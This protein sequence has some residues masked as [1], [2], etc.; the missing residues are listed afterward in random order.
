[1]PS[2]SIFVS[3]ATAD[4][5]LAD[6]LVVLIETGIG[7]PDSDVFC[8]SLEGL[9]IPSGANFVDFIKS[10]IQ[11]PRGVLLLLTPHYY[12]SEFCLCELGAS[13]SMAHRAFPLLLPPLTYDD[14]NGVLLGTQVLRLNSK[15]KLNQFQGEMVELFKIKGKAFAIWE[16]RRD[17]F[18]EWIDGYIKAYTPPKKVDPD[19]HRE[20]EKNYNEAKEALSDAED[21]ISTLEGQIEKLKQLKD[22]AAADAVLEADIEDV[23]KFETLVDEAV[24]AMSGFPREVDNALFLHFRGEELEWP[25]FGYSDSDEIRRDIKEAMEQGFLVDGGAGVTIN[26][27]DP[28]IRKA[29]DALERI[30]TFVRNPSEEFADYYANNYDHQPSLTNKRFW[31][32]HFD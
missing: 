2:K 15:E 20:L 28:L 21:R 3:H 22:K 13:W 16:K 17:E 30:Q 23:E 12:A 5:E 27:E 31:T 18:L 10:Q 6:K 19:K 25:P 11:E 4:K 24:E 8:T 1:M 14:V 26:T 32:E 9:G 29:V 7:I